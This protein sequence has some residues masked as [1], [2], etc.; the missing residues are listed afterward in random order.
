MEETK[1]IEGYLVRNKYGELY[2][3]KG[4]PYKIDDEWKSCQDFEYVG[5]G[6]KDTEFIK[7]EDEEPIEVKIELKRKEKINLY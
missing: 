4:S 1:T 3:T 7:N 2:F 6:S 5:L